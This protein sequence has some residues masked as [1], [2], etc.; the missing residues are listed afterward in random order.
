MLNDPFAGGTH[1]PDIT[2]DD[3][4]PGASATAA[5]SPT[6]P[7]PPRGRLPTAAGALLGFAASRAHHA[8]VGGRVAGLD[9]GGQQDAGGGGRGDP[10][11]RLTE[12]AIARDR[13]A[14]CA[15]PQERRAD[16]RAQLAA[17]RIGAARL[18]SSRAASERSAC[19]EATD[20]VLDYAERRTRACLAALPD[21]AREA[22]DVLEANEGDLGCACEHGARRAADARL[23]RQRRPARGQPQLPAGGDALGVLLRGAGADRPRH[24]PV[25]GRVPA[26]R[27]DRPPRARC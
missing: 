5:A 26:G 14:G 4:D 27:G 21:G 12:E 17:N 8:D 15:S 3:A 24:P 11:R 16:L 25:R 1:L 2:V 9:A 18:R 20:A 22:E 19:G 13:G 6:R 7:P 10:P 23:R